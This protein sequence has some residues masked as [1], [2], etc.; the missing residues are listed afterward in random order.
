[1]RFQWPKQHYFISISLS[2]LFPSPFFS[3]SPLFLLA[4]FREE[5]EGERKRERKER[6]REERDEEGEGESERERERDT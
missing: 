5:R 1:M 3:L 6:E 4:F 2:S